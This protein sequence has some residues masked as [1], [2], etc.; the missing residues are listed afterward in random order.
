MFCQVWRAGSWALTLINYILGCQVWTW[1]RRDTWLPSY[2]LQT[3]MPN[4][5]SYKN[6]GP[7]A[8]D[9]CVSRKSILS[10]A[11]VLD[12]TCWGNKLHLH[13]ASNPRLLFYLTT[14]ILLN[15]LSSALLLFISLDSWK[16]GNK[17]Y[18][19]FTGEENE[20]TG[21]KWLAYNHIPRKWKRL[22]VH[23][24]PRLM[25]FS[26]TFNYVK[27]HSISLWMPS[28]PLSL[29]LLSCPLPHYDILFLSLVASICHIVLDLVFAF[30]LYFIL[31]ITSLLGFVF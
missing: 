7:V 16:V 24:S 10:V 29:L 23:L 11:H 26:A 30:T 4:L 8:P 14:Y 17:Y 21:V 12:A 3:Q 6:T 1:S 5:F 27:T 22:H 9:L 20:F 18:C 19:H 31:E 25:V 15:C 28:I 13:V 2:R